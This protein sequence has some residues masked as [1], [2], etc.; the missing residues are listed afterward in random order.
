MYLHRP[1]LVCAICPNILC[2]KK[3]WPSL[4]TPQMTTTDTSQS[5]SSHCCE[6]HD[7][8]FVVALI[9]PL[10]MVRQFAIYK[11]VIGAIFFLTHVESP[12]CLA[13]CLDHLWRFIEWVWSLQAAKDF[14]DTRCVKLLRKMFGKHHVCRGLLNIKMVIMNEFRPSD[15]LF[16]VIT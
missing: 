5:C 11:L 9:S 3:A 16:S 10:T 15:Q 6:S 2:R 13:L 4:V 7:T 8:G 1:S 14:Q 12:P